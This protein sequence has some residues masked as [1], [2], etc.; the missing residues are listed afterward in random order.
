MPMQSHTGWSGVP[1]HFC[2]CHQKQYPVSQLTRQDGMIKCPTGVDNPQRTL[3]VD[4]R[5]FLIQL[6]LSEPGQEPAI[7]DILTS[8]TDNTTTGF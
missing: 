2:D 8:S 1:W 7:A 3:T 5:Q 4:R 6:V